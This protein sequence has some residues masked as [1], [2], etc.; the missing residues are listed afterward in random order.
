MV[1]KKSFPKTTGGA[2]YPTWEEVALSTEEELEQ[3]KK[4]RIE[5]LKIMDQCVEDAK[6]FITRKNLKSYQTDL[7]NIALAL[8][9]KRA[10]HVV[11]WKERKAKERFDELHK[12]K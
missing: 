9:E 10:S 12:N 3:E 11:Y 5:N 2:R 4:A 7:V 6:L 8:F 1:F